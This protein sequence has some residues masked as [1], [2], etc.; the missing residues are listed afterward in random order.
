MMGEVQREVERL[1]LEEE[2][3]EEFL[4]ILYARS[5]GTERKTFELSENKRGVMTP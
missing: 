4:L 2:P 1:F 3:M 5:S